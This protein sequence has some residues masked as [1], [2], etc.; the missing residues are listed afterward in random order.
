MLYEQRAN[1][2]VTTRLSRANHALLD[3]IESYKTSIFVE[4][5]VGRG[6]LFGN[7]FKIGCKGTKNI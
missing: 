2:A 1:N 5:F 6:G 3:A 4:A 7:T